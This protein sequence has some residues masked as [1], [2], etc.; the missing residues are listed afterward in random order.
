MKVIIVGSGAFGLPAALALSLRGHKVTVFDRLPVPADD[1]ASNDITKV[2]R[3]DYGA[4]AL[5]MGGKGYQDLCIEAIKRFRDL[6]KASVAQTGRKIYYE[7]GVA[8]ATKTPQWNQYERDS[9]ESLKSTAEYKNLLE[10]LEESKVARLLGKEFAAQFP[11]GYINRGA[12]YADSAQTVVHYADLAKKQGRVV[13]IK[14]AD[15]KSH[16]ADA[17]LI[18]AGSW[19][20]SILPELKGLCEPAG[21]PV[22]HFKIPGFYG[23]PL[24]TS[25]ELKF[26]F[27]GAGY[28]STFHE[29]TK[30]T[31]AKPVTKITPRDIPRE[32]ILMYRKFLSTVFPELNNLD[33][34]RT[35]L[36]WYCDS[37]DGNFY[38]DAV[39][40]RNGLF[41][42]TG[43][44]GHAFK[45]MPVIGD[46]IADVVEGK[47]NEYHQS[48]FKWRVPTKEERS[49]VDSLKMEYEKGSKPLE[50]MVMADPDDFTAAAFK[51]GRLGKRDYRAQE[52]R[53][54]IIKLNPNTIFL[55]L[56]FVFR[57]CHR[58]NE[59]N[60]HQRT[61]TFQRD[62]T[63]PNDD[64]RNH[65]WFHTQDISDR[66]NW[67]R[68]TPY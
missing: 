38:I 2:V 30:A 47:K 57:H 11:N 12:G 24:T 39:P 6:D 41:V 31:A 55:L 48:I 32:S 53:R 15:K 21:M 22:I 23:F 33:I 49:K 52:K 25:S 67:D 56:L 5:Y 37:W 64:Y 63:L 36:C 28:N 62:V 9:F 43:G 26:A 68:N 10:V 46:I 16:F 61:N 17:I 42:A 18:A 54:Q 14:T 20:P 3:P 4:D 51:T 59:L 35:R 44:S 8:F 27:H 34:S 13:G 65:I 29:T 40:Q 50:V 66:L 1:S 60:N 45:F 7:C 58:N 19:T